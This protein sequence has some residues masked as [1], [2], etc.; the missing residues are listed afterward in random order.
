M[1][2]REIIEMFRERSEQA[3][4]A[5]ADKY[6][7]RLRRLAL[8]FLGSEQDAEECLNDAWLKAWSSVPRQEINDLFGFLARLVRC[9]AF[10]MLDKRNAAKRS[11]QL[12]ELSEELIQCIPDRSEDFAEAELAELINSFLAAQKK[13]KQQLFV[14]RYF[15][16]M[17]IRELCERTG[18]SESKVNTLLSRMRKELKG[19]LK[20]KGVSV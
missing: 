8:S 19:Y 5:A 9:T 11:A 18:F 10:D 2:D 7:E 3:V 14:L 17:S 1:H 16:G 4:S 13:H 12:V 6:G 15:Y 20:G